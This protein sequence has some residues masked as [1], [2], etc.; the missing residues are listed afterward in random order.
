MNNRFKTRIFTEQ[1]LT[2]GIQITLS[3]DKSHYLANVMRLKNGDE[4]IC[5]NGSDGEYAAQIIA[6]NK[7][8]TRLTIA[9]QLR[10]QQ[11]SP[12]IWLLFAPLKKDRTDFLI[13]KAVELGVTKLIPVIT[14]H[15]ITDKIRPERLKLQIIEAAEQC[16]RL[17][18]PELGEAIKLNDLLNNWN[19]QRILYFMDERGKGRP[20]A[21]VF[22]QNQGAAALL[23][24]P[25]GGFAAEEA[26]L[27]YQLPF[28]KTITL[29]PRILR[30]ETAAAASLAVW[31]AIAGDWKE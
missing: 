15:T 13:E 14:K 30:A 4:L 10:P 27:L 28:V 16:E 7:K 9:N 22:A 3:E 1:P 21:N 2:S 29:G 8:Q 31:Q 19:R 18:I 6:I 26:S 25:E 12:D 11:K 23:I 5:F 17:D 20:C 24:G